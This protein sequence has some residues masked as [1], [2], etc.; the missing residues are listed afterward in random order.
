VSEAAGQASSEAFWEEAAVAWTRHQEAMRDYTEPLSRWLVEAAQLAPGAQVLELAAGLGDTGF[1][2]AARIAPGGRLISTDRAEAMVAA[3]RARAEELA[4]EGVEHR[5][6][7]AEWIDLPVASVDAV[8]CRWGLM[9][10]ADPEAA[11][12]EARRVLRPGGRIALAVWDAQDRNPWSAVPNELLREWGLAGPPAS[13]GPFALG[14]EGVVRELLEGA[15]FQEV[16]VRPLE[17]VER[18]RDFESFWGRRLDLSRAFHDAIM[19]RP[20]PEIERFKEEL[21]ARMEPY[22]APDGTLEVPGRTLVAAA[23]A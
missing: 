1:M 10:L 13:P 16:E 23:S 22:T 7:E 19:E 21:R 12:R 5:V 9:L 11:L 3:S 15:G 18:H 2:A 14:D 8:I 20:A 17:L 4:L 6:M